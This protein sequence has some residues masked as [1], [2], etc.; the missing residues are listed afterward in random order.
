MATGERP[1]G[2]GKKVEPFQ[3][4]HG[5]E[6]CPNLDVK[7]IGRGSDE[8]F[9]FE[10]LL[11][12]FEEDFDLPTVLVNGRDGG[13]AEIEVVGEQDQRILTVTLNNDA[14]E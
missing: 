1:S 11:E 2:R 13:G 4:Q 10:V 8:A 7:G 14:T 12:G 5:D 3:Q 6:S 9:D